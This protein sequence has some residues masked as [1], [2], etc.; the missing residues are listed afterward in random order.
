[1]PFSASGFAALIEQAKKL[2]KIS[3]FIIM[4]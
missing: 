1:M 2:N 4:I 3:T